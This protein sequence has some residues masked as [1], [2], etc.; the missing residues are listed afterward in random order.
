MQLCAG[1][2]PSFQHTRELVGGGGG[3]SKGHYSGVKS[4]GGRSELFLPV[5]PKESRRI[6]G[7]G[8]GKTHTRGTLFKDKG[9]PRKRM[10]SK[11][12]STKPLRLRIWS[13]NEVGNRNVVREV[14]DARNRGAQPHPSPQP[15]GEQTQVKE[16]GAK[17]GGGVGVAITGQLLQRHRSVYASCSQSQRQSLPCACRCL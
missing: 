17:G 2:A 7:G 15:P 14:K 8:G 1:R 12:P 9:G 3:I 13:V 10:L 5:L 16:E 4:G 11:P 6:R